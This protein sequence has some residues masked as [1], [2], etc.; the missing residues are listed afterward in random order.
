MV[1]TKPLKHKLNFTMRV[2][3][4]FAAAVADIQRM[5]RSGTKV[6]TMSDVIRKAVFDERERLR[7]R[8][9]RLKERGD[10]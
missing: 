3:E 4:E 2:D 10:R 9:A 8:Q 5:G 7:G 6:P 1:N